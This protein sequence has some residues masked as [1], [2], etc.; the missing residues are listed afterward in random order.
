MTEMHLGDFKSAAQFK[1]RALLGVSRE[2]KIHLLADGHFVSVEEM[3]KS[4]SVTD[5]LNKAVVY[6]DVV[7]AERTADLV[8]D[9]VTPGQLLDGEQIAAIKASDVFGD[10]WS[11]DGPKIVAEHNATPGGRKGFVRSQVADMKQG[12][13]E[14][15]AS[16]KAFEQETKKTIATAEQKLRERKIDFTKSISDTER[17]IAKLQGRKDKV[18]KKTKKKAA[19]RVAGKKKKKARAVA[20]GASRRKAAGA[21]SG[22]VLK[23]RK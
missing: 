17:R 16:L 1:K 7:T 23:R 4:S 11:D 15:K 19:R 3:N 20:K 2:G 21:R 6:P 14:D 18:K 10:E 5:L 12:I 22:R 8:A 9:D 13:K